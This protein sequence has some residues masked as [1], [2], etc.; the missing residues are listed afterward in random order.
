M[1]HRP[2]SRP[3]APAAS[4]RS[5][6]DGPGAGEPCR[7]CGAALGAPVL[8][9]GSQPVSEFEPTGPGAEAAERRPLRLH[10]CPA[11]GLVQLGREGP[12]P[13]RAGHGHGSAFS[14]TVSAH[15][16]ARVAE[17]GRLAGLG[18]GAL[19][20][21]VA[22][23]DGAALA[24]FATT[25]AEVLGLDAE[26]AVL[27]GAV[28]HLGRR[29]QLVLVDHALAHLDDF[30]GM[31]AALASV[32]A[33]DGLI[34]IEAH[35]VLGLLQDGAFDIVSHPH[36]TYLALGALERALAR[37]GLVAVSAGRS[38][39][40]GGSFSV[41]VRPVAAGI[42]ADSSIAA[43]RAV[44][45]SA[46]LAEPETYRPLAARA[47]AVREEL[48]AAVEAARAAGEIVAA[49]GASSRGLTLLGYAGLTRRE[50][51]FVADRD[52]AKAGRVLAGTGIP[53]RPAEA[54][55][56]ERPDVVLI[57]PWPIAPEIA[58]QLRQIAGWSGRLVVALPAFAEVA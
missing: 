20:V 24:A 19:V 12:E 34:A 28:A 35:H 2:R 53:V 11:C 37:H 29:A 6:G 14:S 49:Y 58:R 3:A 40:H 7:S 52:P 57:L 5:P 42:R 26:P 54:I 44:E 10:C 32:V 46:G 17:L 43:L 1:R 51:A 48:R 30:D 23:G 15:V 41:V 27:P 56:A 18:P 21:D 31:I 22:A 50:I 55:E 39:L 4:S 38:A 13:A 33:A 25:G 47:S 36:R 16:G 9:L 8:D 45:A